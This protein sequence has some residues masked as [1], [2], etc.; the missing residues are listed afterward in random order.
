LIDDK[1]NAMSCR[2]VKRMRQTSN[3]TNDFRMQLSEICRQ[4]AKRCDWRRS[5]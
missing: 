3:M 5:L 1:E 2:N 4:R